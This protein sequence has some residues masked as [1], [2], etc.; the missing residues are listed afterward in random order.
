MTIKEQLHQKIEQTD[1]A[2]LSKWLEHLTQLEEQQAAK[3][4][5]AISIWEALAEPMSEEDAE[6]FA[7]ATKRRPFFRENNFS[8]NPD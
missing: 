8:V 3:R 2:V 4:Q 6:L 7:E 1:E 5:K